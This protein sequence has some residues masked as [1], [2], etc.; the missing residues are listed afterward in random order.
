M[1]VEFAAPAGTR[2]VIELADGLR[3]IVADDPAVELAAQLINAL[4]KGGCR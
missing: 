3:L 2:L 1:E 4:R